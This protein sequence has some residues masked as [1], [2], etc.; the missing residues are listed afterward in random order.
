ARVRVDDR[1]IAIAPAS[2]SASVDLVADETARELK[3]VLVAADGRRETL[4]TRATAT[5]L[6]VS[7]R[8]IGG[9]APPIKTRTTPSAPAPRA[10]Q[11]PLQ[12]RG[13]WVG[14]TRI[15]PPAPANRGGEGPK[16]PPAPPLFRRPAD[17]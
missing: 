13:G 16:R 15:V 7:F 2:R 17:A 8:A 10:H 6:D 4:A 11:G 9:R 3:I 5:P 12:G 1:E 14:R